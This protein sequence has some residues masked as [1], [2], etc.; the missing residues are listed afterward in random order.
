VRIE[1]VRDIPTLFYALC[2]CTLLGSL[3][4][5]GYFVEC[6]KRY[7]GAEVNELKSPTLLAFLSQTSINCFNR[8]D[9][10]FFFFLH[11]KLLVIR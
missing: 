10:P 5:L 1:W 2:N 7:Y 11:S 9:Y 6:K 3:V 8:L 4:V